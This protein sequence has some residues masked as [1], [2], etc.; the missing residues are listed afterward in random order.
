MIRV[1]KDYYPT[2]ILLAISAYMAVTLFGGC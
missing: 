2:M 1:I